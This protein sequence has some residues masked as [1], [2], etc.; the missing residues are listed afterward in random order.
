M[1]CGVL[2][3]QLRT[4]A[5]TGHQILAH[6]HVVLLK[7]N[8]QGFEQSIITVIYNIIIMFCQSIICDYPRVAKVI[9]K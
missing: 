9:L 3:D 6:A 7:S 5:V 4:L 1:M 8:M 2:Y